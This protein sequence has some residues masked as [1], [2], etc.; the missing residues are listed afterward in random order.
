MR[1]GPLVGRAPELEIF[2]RVWERVVAGQRQIVF[3]GGEPGAG[4]TRM[5][6]EVAGVLHS[7]GVAGL[8]GVSTQDA[9]VPYQAFAEILDQIF[10]AAEPGSLADHVTPAGADLGRLSG[11]AERHV[12]GAVP[13]QAATEVRRD[14]F[15]AVVGLLRA[16]CEEAPLLLVL[17]DLHWAQRP[18]IALLDHLAREAVDAPLLVIGTFRTTAP[19]RSD[20]LAQRIAE[21]HR[22]EGVRRLDLGGL[23]TD[24]IAEYIGRQAG[25]A[26]SSVRAPAALLRDRTGGN[27]FFLRELWTDLEAHGG[28][29][30]LSSPL[31]VPASIGDTVE[32]RLAGLG[33]SA[34][35]ILD[36][37][38]VVGDDFDVSTVATA[39]GIEPRSVLD[40]LDSA[41]AVG[42]VAPTSSG[43]ASFA[44]IHSLTREAVLARLAPS[45]LAVLHSCVGSALEPRADD[46]SVVP[47][48]AHHFL[49]AHVLGHGQEAIRYATRAGELAEASLAFEEAAVWYERAAALPGNTS[50]V[51][52]SLLFAAAANHLRAGDFARARGIYERLA[53]V[54]DPMAR[55]RAA[56][57]YEDA[58]W[59]PGLANTKAAD[60]LAS[61]LSGSDLDRSDTRYVQALGSLGRAL[62]FAGETE[63]ARALGSHAIA[64]AEET[65]DIPTVIHTLKTSLWHGLGPEMADVQ[66][67]RATRLCAMARAAEDFDTLGSAAYFRAMAAYV[68]GDPSALDE[69][70]AD[71][72]IA[73]ERN[74]QPFFSY[75]AGCVSQGRALLSGDFTAATQWAERTL[76][77][78]D[79]FGPDTTEGS[80]GVQMFM[81]ARETGGLLGRATMVDGTESFESRWVPGMLALYTEMDNRRGIR[82]ALDHLLKRDLSAH[83]H[84]AQWPMELVF[85]T[86]GALALGDTAALGVLESH[87]L[88]Y[89]GMNLISGQFVAPFGSADRF[90]ARIAVA[91]GRPDEA[92]ARFAAATTL[93][94]RMGS[95]IHEAESV[96]WHARFLM[97]RDPARA[98]A[99]AGR[100]HELATRTGQIRIL[101]VLEPISDGHPDGLT[102]REVEV[103]GLLAAGLS[104]REI[105]ERLYIS[106][107]TAANH[108]RSILMKTRAANRTQAAVY[109]TE[110]DLA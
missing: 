88:R 36:V 55:L 86:E 33:Q 25:L 89:V 47:R 44:F 34:R 32:L 15:D 56:M 77:L 38:A 14:L 97:S 13:S 5:A 41:T 66:L 9:G 90:L 79:S 18:T 72:R 51:R 101:R 107:N 53:T 65:G 23:D 87:L 54:P 45:R 70:S 37:A 6:A 19:D 75:V 1:L 78:G 4:K 57:G 83:V 102:S 64:A 68:R 104:N 43:E 26:P 92:E 8:L 108:V 91:L 30:A 71:G 76:R 95:V 46:P 12:S 100:A 81:V 24:A 105:A 96:A 10:L 110:H 31:R 58:N 69:A 52:S 63:R 21:M 48:V 17:D 99:L 16:L 109:A 11:Y 2:E 61:A 93:D 27:P 67:A 59:R 42:L 3:I 22:Q 7:H 84:D 50:E 39:G 29:S 60:L 106:P 82:R 28:V 62:A 94:K 85:M 74:A 35:E 20:E 73:A 49:A 80:Y 98:S 103:L 40:A